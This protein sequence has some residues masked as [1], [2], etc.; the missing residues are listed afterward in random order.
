[1]PAKTAAAA[2]QPTAANAASDPAFKVGDHV[3]LEGGLAECQVWAVQQPSP[4][5]RARGAQAAYILIHA[6]GHK[7]HNVQADRLAPSS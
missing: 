2:D 7:S 4:K 6:D 1:M 5:H 3:F